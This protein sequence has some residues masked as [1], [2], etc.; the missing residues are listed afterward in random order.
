MA[1]VAPSAAM[2]G[3]SSRPPRPAPAS[4]A[5]SATLGA[6]KSRLGGRR[7]RQHS[8]PSACSASSGS[9][10][11]R[12]ADEPRGFGEPRLPR[13]VREREHLALASRRAE[14]GE[15][16]AGQRARSPRRKRPPGSRCRWR[17]SRSRLHAATARPASPRASRRSG[18]PARRAPRRSAARSPPQRARQLDRGRLRF[19]RHRVDDEPSAGL[20]RVDA[21][22]RSRPGS[23]APP[24]TNTASGPGR[25]SSACGALPMTTVRAGAPKAARCGRCGPP[26]RRAPRWRRRDCPGRRASIRSPRNPSRRRRPKAVRRA[27]ARAPKG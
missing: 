24:P 2:R 22:G 17:R 1:Q 15:R 18:R 3:P 16:A 11:Q 8:R 5:A 6:P 20:Q 26:G 25:P 12:R 9:A 27:A 13:L 19:E 21:R 14:L 23:V 10:D 4:A 7:R